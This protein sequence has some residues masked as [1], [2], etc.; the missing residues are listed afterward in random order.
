MAELSNE[1]SVTMNTL[2]TIK[3]ALQFWFSLAIFLYKNDWT[4]NI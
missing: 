4:N 1:Y 2:K 3:L